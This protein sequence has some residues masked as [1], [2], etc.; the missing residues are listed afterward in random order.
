[1]DCTF[2]VGQKVV[3]S[4]TW[5][6]SFLEE[7]PIAKQVYTIRD[8]CCYPT[9]IFLR[10]KEVRNIPKEWGDGNL[11]EAS[12]KHTWFRPVKEFKN[13]ISIFTKMLIPT[14]EHV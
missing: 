14:L 6:H 2:V 4:G 1:M 7:W 11:R 8:V 10:F 5:N 12:F 13:D 3:S 9:G